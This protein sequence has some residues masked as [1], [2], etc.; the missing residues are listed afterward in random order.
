M[1]PKEEIKDNVEESKNKET[2]FIND[3]KRLV[4]ED[5]MTCSHNGKKEIREKDINNE[6]SIWIVIAKN[7]FVSYNERWNQIIYL[8]INIMR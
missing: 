3:L 1:L 5:N 7:V 8:N 6:K 2:S 4:N